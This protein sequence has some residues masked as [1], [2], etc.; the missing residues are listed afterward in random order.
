MYGQCSNGL[1]KRLTGHELAER[2]MALRLH[3]GVCET[4]HTEKTVQARLDEAG[5][6]VQILGGQ[7]RE[8]QSSCVATHP[9]LLDN[10]MTA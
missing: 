7:I 8:A 2:D 6:V 5:Q 10:I 3:A 4:P 9:Q 1:G